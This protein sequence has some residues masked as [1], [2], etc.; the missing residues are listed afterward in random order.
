MRKDINKPNYTVELDFT[1][2]E[3]RIFIAPV[4]ERDKFNV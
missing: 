3:C 1:L 2:E 4:K